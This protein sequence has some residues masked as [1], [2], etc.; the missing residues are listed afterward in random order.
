[1]TKP[2]PKVEAV[3]RRLHNAQCEYMSALA[4]HEPGDMR[5]S[6]YRSIERAVR[7]GLELAATGGGLCGNRT[8]NSGVTGG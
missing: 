3:V 7:A 8:S 2:D 5:C 4:I 6:L 1:M